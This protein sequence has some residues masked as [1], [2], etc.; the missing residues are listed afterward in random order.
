MSGPLTSRPTICLNMIV[1]NEAH[2]VGEVIDSIAPYI[3]AWVIVD[4]GSTDGTQR[5]IRDRMGELGIDGEL[6]ERQWRDFGHN[7]SEAIALARGHADYIWVMDADDLLVGTP[8]FSGLTADVY[9]LQY[10]PDVTYWR[11]QLF[12]DGLPWRYVGVLHEYADCDGPFTED[13]L[14]G[15]YHIE[16]RRLGNRNLDPEKYA[17]DAEVLLAEVDRHPDDARSVFYL[18][19]SYYDYRDFVNA[20]RWYQRRS[21]MTG[22]DEETFY[23]LLRVADTMSHLGEPWPEVQQAYLRAWEFRPTRAE[24]LYSIARSYRVDGRHQLGHLFASDAARIPLPAHD[25]LFVAA[26]IYLWR[27]DD[28]Q[29]VCA[30]W[31]GRHRETVDLC[32]RILRRNDVPEEDRQRIVANRDC[33]AP[34]ILDEMAAYPDCEVRD[35][36][37]MARDG[38]VTVTVVAGPDRAVTERTLSSFLRCCTDFRALGPVLIVDVGMAAED[39]EAL[40]GRYPFAEI[41]H[42]SPGARPAQIRD[43]VDTRFWLHLGMG[44]QF[45]TPD[46]YLTRLVAVLESDPGVYQV[47]VNYGNADTFTNAI[48][49]LN[50]VRCTT[51]GHRYVPA[52]IVAT[53]P[54]MFDCGRLGGSESH[55]GTATLDEVLC[56]LRD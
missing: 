13:K 53:G 36:A 38:E 42:L 10:G 6:H 24:P 30:S 1:R 18:A 33:S 7:R 28:E 21:E 52:D 12:R 43:E 34:R 47:G 8:D 32:R 5:K 37:A 35:V 16:S 39:R 50:E 9:Q 3:D 20:R 48:A 23:A 27:A 25:A 40:R 44:W 15:S 56:I 11:R 17:R 22:F 55:Y 4:T 2:I 46:D 51:A 54:A 41:R 31:I 26:E 49:P 14:D 45:F 19:Q 29:A